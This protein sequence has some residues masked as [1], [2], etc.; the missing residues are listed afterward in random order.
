MKKI[1]YTVIPVVLIILLTIL[2]VFIF[3]PDDKKTTKIT[4]IK[5]FSF[6]YSEGYAANSYTRYKLECQAK[7]IA[8]IK[9]Y[10]MLEEDIKEYEVNSDFVN[11]LIDLFNKYE[12]VSWDGF[13]RVAKDVLDGDSF[14]FFL[15]IQGDIKIE[16]SGYMLWPDNYRIVREE[17]NS[18]FNSINEE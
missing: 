8:T 14:S 10:G 17:I 15:W 3:L 1:L 13:D 18:L 11:K 7:C 4:E 2:L 9:P 12:V 16:A 5:R 6:E